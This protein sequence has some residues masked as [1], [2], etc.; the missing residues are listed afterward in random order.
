MKAVTMS[1]RFRRR[2]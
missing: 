2:R 1:A